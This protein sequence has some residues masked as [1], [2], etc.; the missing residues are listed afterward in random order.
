M[1]AWYFAGAVLLGI[2]ASGCRTNLSRD[3]LEQELRMQ[4]D[5][6]YELQGLVEEYQ[7]QLDS[8]QRENQSL[9]K[10]HAAPASSRDSRSSSRSRRHPSGGSD[11]LALPQVE[12]PAGGQRG[13]SAPAYD[14]PPVISPPD[15]EVP[16]GEHRDEFESKKPSNAKLP[17]SITVPGEDNSEL[18]QFELPA[19][20]DVPDEDK[21]TGEKTTGD[22]PPGDET[23]TQI[24]LNR[25]LTGGHNVDGQPGDDGLMVVIEPLDASGELVEVPGEVSVVVLDPAQEGEAARVARWDFTTE[26]AAEHIKRTPMGDGLHFDLRWP[27]GPP[28]NRTLNLYVRFKTLEGK[29]LQLEKEIEVR[30]P[31]QAE[32]SDAAPAWTKADK[33]APEA[34]ASTSDPAAPPRAK[35]TAIRPAPDDSASKTDRSKD[36]RTSRGS[37]P[38]WTPYR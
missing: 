19:G 26:E 11:E 2:A 36:D 23:V 34:E 12:M 8:C 38:K 13:G 20:S 35:A 28:A 6:I 7:Q 15:P 33:A 1:N 31:G 27:H 4:E 10:E 24:S 32:S 17:S 18:P 29:K 16:E 21:M 14:G 30:L 3:L 37:A 9:L 5:K 25:K 22:E